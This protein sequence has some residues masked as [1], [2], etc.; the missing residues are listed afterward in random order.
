M[1]TQIM[2]EIQEFMADLN[3]KITDN[4]E[5]DFGVSFNISVMNVLS[6]ILSGTRDH[7]NFTT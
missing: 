7:S 2:D 4:N 1:E 6:R 5:V 3:S